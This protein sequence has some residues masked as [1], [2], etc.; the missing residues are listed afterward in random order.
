MLSV[1]ETPE[2]RH[3]VLP[4]T[5]KTYHEMIEKGIVH[6]G[7]YATVRGLVERA[8]TEIGLGHLL[9]LLHF[10][11]LPAEQTRQNIMGYAAE[12]IAPLKRQYSG[13]V[14]A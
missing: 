3:R 9:P 11:T 13:E 12:I 2:V 5:V 10:G 1:L 14:A 7:S 6:V 8:R 4:I